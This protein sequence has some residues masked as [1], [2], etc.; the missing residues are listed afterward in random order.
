MQRFAGAKS[1]DNP[2]NRV[3]H[4]CCYADPICLWLW[5][6]SSR[7]STPRI[8]Y[9][10]RSSGAARCAGLNYDCCGGGC[11]RLETYSSSQHRVAGRFHFGR[12]SPRTPSTDQHTPTCC[13]S[14]SR[15]NHYRLLCIFVIFADEP[16]TAG[17]ET[18][19]PP[20][21]SDLWILCGNFGRRLR[22]ERS[23]T[24]YFLPASIIGMSGYWLAGLWTRPVTRYYLISLPGI[25]LGIFAGR[26]LNRRLHDRNFA[27]YIYVGLIAIGVLLLGQALS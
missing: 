20:L 27:K 25:L 22:D 26:V 6:S 16:R 7:G 2:C 15:R 11:T 3:D 12:N 23:S 17:I 4:F 10:D 9:S 14:P 24:G 21:A 5:R 19:Q 13:K 1:P 18:R 8:P